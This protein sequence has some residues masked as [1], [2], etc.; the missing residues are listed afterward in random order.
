ME[1]PTIT[2]NDTYRLFVRETGVLEANLQLDIES[3]NTRG[4]ERRH[5]GS[6][7][8]LKD[9]AEQTI[10][11][12]VLDASNQIQ[13]DD[14]VV[15]NAVPPGRPLSHDE[16]EAVGHVISAMNKKNEEIIAQTMSLLRQ[17]LGEEDFAKLDAY[18][19]QLENGGKK[20]AWP[21]PSTV[22]REDKCDP[23]KCIVPSN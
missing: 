11:S 12:I 22:C 16:A 17:Q 6:C 8:G 14:Q 5:F 19:Y 2:R 1:L 13:T 23:K 10:Y 15:R 20:P 3:G 18:I 21:R 9:G 7:L 4:S